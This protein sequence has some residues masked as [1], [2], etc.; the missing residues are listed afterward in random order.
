MRCVTCTPRCSQPID[1]KK[2]K[3]PADIIALSEVMATNT[4]EVW[5]AER[6]AAGWRHG[7]RRDNQLRR[8]PELVPYDLL[9]ETEKD[10]DRNSS[11]QVLKV[12]LV[13]LCL[14]VAVSHV[15][16][17]RALRES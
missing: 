10:Y 8:H 14:P 15:G 12:R 11:W 17:K 6:M 4:H 1:T 13:M 5:C 3:L 2:I 9:Q 16:G 7:R